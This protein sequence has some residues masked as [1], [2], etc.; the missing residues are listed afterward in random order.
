MTSFE[1]LQSS[2][3]SDD[4]PNGNDPAWLCAASNSVL[5]LC[6]LL[7]C[8]TSLEVVTLNPFPA[9]GHWAMGLT[10]IVEFEDHAPPP[11]RF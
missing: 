7:T 5:L 6:C 9:Y 4:W 10:T 2:W 8:S 3:S 1:H 11:H